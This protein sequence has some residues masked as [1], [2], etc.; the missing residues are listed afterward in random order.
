MAKLNRDDIA[1]AVRE[2]GPATK[3]EIAAHL[4][5]SFD[6]IALAFREAARADLIQRHQPDR[7][8]GITT[9]VTP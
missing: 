5:T 8:R 9:S 6:N 1:D 2:L 4:G 3:E 7:L